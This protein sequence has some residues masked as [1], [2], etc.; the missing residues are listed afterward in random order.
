[1]VIG[2][3]G[4]DLGR[5]T[6]VF[7]DALSYEP[8]WMTVT[9]DTWGGAEAVVPLALSWLDEGR[10]SVP[11]ST[12]VVQEAPRADT[13]MGLLGAQHEQ[14]LLRHYGLAGGDA[15]AAGPVLDGIPLATPVSGADRSPPRA[16]RDWRLPRVGTSVYALRGELRLF[17]N[18]S[19]LPGDELD[20]LVLATSEAAVNA[21]E[22]PEHA[23]ADL[24]DVRADIDGS[25]VSITIRDYGRWRDP[26]PGNGRGRGLLLMS[27][28]SGLGITVDPHGTTVTLRN[29][30]PD[31]IGWTFRRRGEIP[32]GSHPRSQG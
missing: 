12:A 21:V 20:D 31:V 4:I 6:Q 22:H 32:A 5:I 1:V 7:L 13:S 16:Q 29:R 2:D 10:I 23:V 26:R 25:Q 14:D 8:A 28:L 30:S 3:A 24:F 11:Y 9:S 18:V 19:S 27:V 17:L 15:V